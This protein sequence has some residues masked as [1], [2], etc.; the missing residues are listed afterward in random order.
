M[1]THLRKI[2]QKYGTKL[3]TIKILHDYKNNKIS[4]REALK[5][6]KEV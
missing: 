2:K 3:A 6:L 5:L 1:I 4:L